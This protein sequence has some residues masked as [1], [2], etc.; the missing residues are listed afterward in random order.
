MLH[1]PWR[2]CRT[3]YRVRQTDLENL[4]DRRN[5]TAYAHGTTRRSVL[6]T[7]RG[8]DLVVSNSR[9]E[10]SCHLCSHRKQLLRTRNDYLGR[11][12]RDGHED[13]QEVVAPSAQPTR[14]VEQWL[15]GRAER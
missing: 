13:G 7:I 3:R 6:R 4:C 1:V 12:D 11:G 15:R 5:A 14:C 10:A 9:L 8:S 2:R